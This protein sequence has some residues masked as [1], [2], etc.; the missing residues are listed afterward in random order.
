MTG[1]HPLISV[2]VASLCV[3]SD[4]RIGDVLTRSDRIKIGGVGC[5]ATFRTWQFGGMWSG[6]GMV[7]V[8]VGGG[9]TRLSQQV[10]TSDSGDISR[11]LLPPRISLIKTARPVSDTLHF[12]ATMPF[13][14]SYQRP[15]VEYPHNVHLDTPEDEYDYNFMYEV[16]TLSSDRVEVRPFLVSAS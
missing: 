9:L 14:N 12:T 1:E 5:G 16:K 6:D 3:R 15:K 11:A 7:E 2:G 10:G 8:E 13:A 4:A